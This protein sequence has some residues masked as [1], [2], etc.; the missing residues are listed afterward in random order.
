MRTPFSAPEIPIDRIFLNFR[1]RTRFR[2][3]SVRWPRFMTIPAT[4]TP[5]ALQS[6]GSTAAAVP[7]WLHVM[8]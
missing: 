3:S 6:V 5:P 2:W 8:M 1:I 4:S 7:R